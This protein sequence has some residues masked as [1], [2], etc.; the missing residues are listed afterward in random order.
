MKRTAVARRLVERT[1]PI[2]LTCLA[3]AAACAWVADPAAALTAR[4]SVEQ[5]HVAG[6]SRA[7]G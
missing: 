1:G 7:R 4:G 6:P 2:A 3:A 5:V